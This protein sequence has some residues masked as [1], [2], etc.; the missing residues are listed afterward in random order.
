MKLKI[1]NLTGWKKTYL[2]LINSKRRTIK[3]LELNFTDKICEVDIDLNKYAYIKLTNKKYC[4][5]IIVLS[6][7]LHELIIRYNR[8]KKNYDVYLSDDSSYGIVNSYVLKDDKNLYFRPKHTKKIDVLVPHNYDEN[9]KYNLLIMFDGQNLFDK[10][11]SGNYTK[12]NDP[13]G[14]WQIDVSIKNLTRHYDEEFIVVGIENTD[15]LRMNELMQ[16]NEFGEFKEIVKPMIDPMFEGHL[17]DL[18]NFINETVLPFI[19]SKYSINLDM[20]GIGGSSC[21]G[22]ACHYVGMK[23]YQKYKFI[24]CYTPV[25][26]FYLDSAWRNLYSKMDMSKNLP[27]FF[28]FQGRKGN[29]ERQLYTLNTNLIDTMLECGYPKELIN[30]YID[31]GLNHNEISWRYAFNYMIYH[32]FKNLK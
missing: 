24:L 22:G 7:N 18:D 19:T 27:Y 6:Q 3:I 14:S 5:E 11:N 10:K 16:N 26:G 15:Y 29:L 32:T 4:S 31:T 9:K 2:K 23:N 30:T 25:S 17:D 8:R 1:K 20:I 12:L 13:Y 28:F 21:G